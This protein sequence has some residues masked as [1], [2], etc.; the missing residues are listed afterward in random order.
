VETRRD[1]LFV[2]T[3]LLIGLA[4]EGAVMI[5]LRFTGQP[6]SFAGIATQMDIT[7]DG[8]GGEFVR[9]GGTVGAAN[10]TAGYLTLLLTP[11][12][13]ILL[14]RLGRGYKWLAALAF[15]LGAVALLMTFSRGGW[16]AFLASL[17]IMIPIAGRRGRGQSALPL[18]LAIVLVAA[19][20]PFYDEIL[21]RLTADD[22]GSA[23][24]RLPLN[25][26]AWQM[27]WDHPALGV[28]V[29]N[30]AVL[31]REYAEREGSIIWL[32]TVH[33]KYL[34]VWAE[35][36]TVALLAFVAFLL[37]S[38]RNGWRVWRSDDPVLSPIALG[39]M[40]AVIGHSTHMLVEPFHGRPAPQ[41]LWLIAG[42]LVAMRAQITSERR[43]DP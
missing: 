7:A 39:M 9:A 29:N 17:A 12:L 23:L 18:A 8:R 2:I 36:G 31:L 40:A 10:H 14:A 15:L 38:V 41:L 37:G 26:I 33:N 24:S 21:A 6:L 3:M 43:P 5:G 30:S 1:V 11:A 27:I 4:L 42:L 22:S 28:G 35:T 34:L 20:L 25:R 19:T 16:F 13:G 32:Y